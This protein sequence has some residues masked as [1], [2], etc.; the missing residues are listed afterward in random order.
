MMQ[1]PGSGHIAKCF[2]QILQEPMLETLM[3]NDSHLRLFT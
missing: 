2:I 3:M 1:F